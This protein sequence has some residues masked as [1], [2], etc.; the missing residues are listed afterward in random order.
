[1]P[2]FR[3][4]SLPVEAT[5]EELTQTL[6]QKIINNEY[7][8]GDLIVPQQ[9]ERVVL[10]NG[11]IYN[12]TVEVAGRKMSLF[13]IRRDM[14]HKH[15]QY[16]KLF[17]DCSL[18]NL[19]TPQL[20]EMLENVHENTIFSSKAELIQKI[21]TLQR[22]RHLMFWH[23]GSSLASHSYLLILVSCMYDP[24][25]FYTDEEYFQKTKKKSTCAANCR[26]S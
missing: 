7:K 5:N 22:T 11:Q 21:K 19:Q 25:V 12:E 4:I 15:K 20:M 1:M 16:M 8:L 26:K 13:D 24:A 2:N 6:K 10:R 3:D 9:F 23:D 17:D 18:E 14:L